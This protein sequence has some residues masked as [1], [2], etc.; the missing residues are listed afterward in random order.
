[1]SNATPEF[2]HSHGHIRHKEN[3]EHAYDSMEAFDGKSEGEHI[4]DFEFDVAKTPLNR[5][6]PRQLQKLLSEVN[7]YDLSR[8]SDCRRSLQSRSSSPATNIEHS[9]T[10]REGSQFDRS[11]SEIV[12][13]AEWRCIVEICRRVVR[14]CSASLCIFRHVCFHSN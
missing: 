5:F 1:W 11:T 7:S 14:K 2:P 13:E 12:P 8:R 6:Y 4:A 10:D 3:S 9:R